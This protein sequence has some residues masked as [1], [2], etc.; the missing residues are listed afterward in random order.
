MRDIP[1]QL[2][3][4]FTHRPLAGNALAVF[5]DADGMDAAPMQALARETNLSESSFVF[6]PT[7]PELTPRSASS[8]RRWS[9]R[10][11]VPDAG[12]RLRPRHERRRRS[13]RLRDGPRRR[14]DPPELG[15]GTSHV[16]MDDPA[17][18]RIAPYGA[19]A[20]LMAALGAIDSTLPV[21]L[22]DNGPHYVYVGLDTLDEVA[23]LRPDLSRLAPW[24]PPHPA[25]LPE[26]AT[27]GS[28]ASSP[29]GRES[30]RIPPPAP[31]R[32]RSRCTSP[33]MAASRSAMRSSSSKGSRSDG[34]RRC[35]RARV[36]TPTTARQ[37]RGRRASR[38]RRTRNVR[39][40]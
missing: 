29:P 24:G 13:I 20:V 27:P 21:E 2:C 3:D 14:G 7:S 8:R 34:H 19:A 22:Y 26:K 30:R 36:G 37:R 31:L 16:R 12:D 23:A 28:A 40:P 6:R 39:R 35:M 4:V 32:D 11:R 9:F 15:S 1:Y 10:S 17:A 5:T 33:A 25:S 18:A 38:H